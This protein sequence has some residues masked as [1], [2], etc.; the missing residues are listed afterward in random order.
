MWAHG[1]RTDVSKTA[2]LAVWT[3]DGM[4]VAFTL[5]AGGH[6]NFRIARHPGFCV[7]DSHTAVLSTVYWCKVLLALRN[8]R[9][10]LQ[11]GVVV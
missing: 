5:E 11:V 3:A 4:S 2:G 10:R 7:I 1:W 8:L 9:E 6:A